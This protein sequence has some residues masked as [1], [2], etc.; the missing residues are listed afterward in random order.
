MG[1]G[2]RQLT[3]KQIQ[4]I[5]KHLKNT[6]PHSQEEKCKL[7]IYAYHF[8]PI[9]LKNS[10]IW[11]NYVGETKR[12]TPSFNAWWERMVQNGK[13]TQL[14]TQHCKAKDY[15]AEC[16]LTYGISVTDYAS[17]K[18]NKNQEVGKRWIVFNGIEIYSNHTKNK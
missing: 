11:E 8:W 7:N 16:P 9:M 13:H 17:L 14:S 10:K 12:P 18:K 2:Q 1:K 3:E 5:P 15:T 4:M 6:Q